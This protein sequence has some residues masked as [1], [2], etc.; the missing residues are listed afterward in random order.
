MKIEEQDGDG[1]C[2]FRSVAYQV[3]GQE[4]LHMYLR[5]SCM[6]YILECR[7]YFKNFVDRDIDGSIESY[8]AR[9]RQDK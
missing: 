4:E 6:D 2:L 5:E 1:N 8:C 9:K 7:D 3:Y